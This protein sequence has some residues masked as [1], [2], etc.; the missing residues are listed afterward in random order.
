MN[1]KGIFALDRFHWF[2]LEIKDTGKAPEDY[3]NLIIGSDTQSCIE[4]IVFEAD[5]DE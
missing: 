3:H 1:E 4:N 5:E 2:V